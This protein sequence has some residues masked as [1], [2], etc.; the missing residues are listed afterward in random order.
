MNICTDEQGRK[1]NTEK[2][3]QWTKSSENAEDVLQ[4]V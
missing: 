2:G 1:W 4:Y 3:G